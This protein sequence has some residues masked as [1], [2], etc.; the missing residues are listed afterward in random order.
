[1]I[2]E[3]FVRIYRDTAFAFCCARCRRDKISRI[4]HAWATP[5]GVKTICNGC[6]NELL[7]KGEQ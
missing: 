7:A 6:R 4:A 5:E 2:P 3:P 1:M